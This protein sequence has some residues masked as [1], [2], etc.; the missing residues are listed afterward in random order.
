MN[1]E[2]AKRI[3]LPEIL[4]KIGYQ[5]ENIKRHEQWYL[6][7]LRNEHT[8]SFKVNTYDNV[9][10]DFGEGAGGDN[11]AFVCAYL[12]SRNE[13]HTVS[14][15]LRW[16]GNMA[17][18]GPIIAP[19][20]TRECKKSDPKLVLKNVQ[21][22]GNDL[23]IEYVESR[24]I[25]IWIARLHLKQLRIYNRDTGK[26]FAA[27]GF[28]NESGAYEARNPYIKITIG[29]HKDITFIRG[30]IVKPPGIYIFEGFFDYLSF[31]A[32]QNGQPSE[33]DIIVLNSLSMLQEATAMIKGFGYRYLCSW[34]DN[35][36]AGRKAT[37]NIAAFCA[38][39]QSIL[40]RP[41]NLLYEKHKD[42]NAWHMHTLSLS[43]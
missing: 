25:P 20:K 43:Q 32:R 18:L 4:D 17:G 2:Q 22:I 42:V 14:D 38:A 41:M 29:E 39:E 15:A 5:P 3:P 10:Y 36:D 35:D 24:G 30:T 31:L 34:M 1:I 33:D 28:I 6:S 23:L 16:L 27:L 11:I 19:V 12:K 8:A 7:P 21:E 9:W 13:D 37:E 26:A 40:H